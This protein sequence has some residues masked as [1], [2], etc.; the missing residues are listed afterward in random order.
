MIRI[1]AVSYLNTKPFLRGLEISDLN[2][3][4][5][6]LDIPS[7]CARKLLENEVDLG[8][9][10]VAVIPLLKEAHIIPGYCIGADGPVESVKLYSQVPLSEIKTILLDYQSRTSV[11]LVR[12]LASELWNISPE[13]KK[14]GIGFEETISGSS[15]GVVIGDR[16]FTMNGTFP[17]EFDLA[18]EWKKLTGL[19]FI[20]ACW[21]SNKSLSADFISRFSDAMELGLTKITEVV[22]KESQKY[23]PFDV[24]KY[25]SKS[26][27]LRL[28][29]R[30]EAAIA[31]FLGKM[32]ELPSLP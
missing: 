2:D 20:F 14:A 7:E 4:S 18:E 12:I 29:K 3:I 21:V 1:S 22:S 32:K 11:T 31:L 6:S 17:Y 26:L 25:L 9:I 8:L 28:D 16:T 24:E 15:A 19:P 30:G 27:N 10:P 23:V 13:W 5:L